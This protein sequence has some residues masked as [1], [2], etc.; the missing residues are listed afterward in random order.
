MST[1]PLPSTRTRRLRRGLAIGLL[2]GLLVHCGLS[3]HPTP[4]AV[5]SGLAGK[6]VSDIAVS[7]VPGSLGVMVLI[8][9][10]GVSSFSGTATSDAPMP[11]P[12]D[13]AQVQSLAG[14][15]CVLHRDGSANCLGMYR[16]MQIATDVAQI[17]T[18][19]ARGG[20]VYCVLGRSGGVRCGP[21]PLEGQS[22]T[23]VALD[24]G[25]QPVSQIAGSYD[26][27]CGIT[28]PDAVRCWTLE[29]GTGTVQ[30]PPVD[31]RGLPGLS[32]LAVYDH[33]A[34]AV[35][36]DGRVTCWQ[37]DPS[38][39]SCGGLTLKPQVVDGLADVVEVA[40]GDCR[41][42]ARKRD[43]GVLCWGQ[44]GLFADRPNMFGEPPAPL[45]GLPP[46]KK[47]MLGNVN[48]GEDCLLS[49]GGQVYC[50]GAFTT[51]G[52]NGGGCGPVFFI[53]S[54]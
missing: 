29:G 34:C 11:M 12:F 17:V 44:S 52:D 36:G 10:E 47:L 32:Q 33:T 21:E 49:T 22:F 8:A 2:S 18:L 38:T 23:A 46:A 54:R 51:S 31:V 7:G 50:W 39:T 13:P 20:A 3:Y 35:L 6:S 43:G 30:G 15:S 4:P 14:G 37:T 45:V 53:P 5:V 25:S 16:P 9:G 48:V 26:T 24:T 41:G 1:F 19:I 28:A 40:L 27:L 42:C